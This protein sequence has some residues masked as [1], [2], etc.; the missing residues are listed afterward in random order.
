[1]MFAIMQKMK[2]RISNVPS[3]ELKTW[4]LDTIL[5]FNRFQNK[6]N[7]PAFWITTST[8]I[9]DILVFFM[10]FGLPVSG[11]YDG[12][13]LAFLMTGYILIAVGKIDKMQKFQKIIVEQKA[14]FRVDCDVERIPVQLR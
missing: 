7:I 13:V 14:F 3:V 1:M 8:Q 11:S 2:E 5:L 9:F 10:A 6:F 12:P 4:A